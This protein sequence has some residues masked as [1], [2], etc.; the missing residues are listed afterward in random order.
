MYSV[1]IKWHR[2]LKMPSTTNV[3]LAGPDTDHMKCLS[4]TDWMS[5][6]WSDWLTEWWSYTIGWLTSFGVSPLAVVLPKWISMKNFYYV[7]GEHFSGAP[8]ATQCNTKI[9]FKNTHLGFYHS[10][11]SSLISVRFYWLKQVIHSFQ[12]LFFKNA[13]P[14]MSSNNEQRHAT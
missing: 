3:F 8:G 12:N 14:K 5:D 10:K 1:N 11:S 13:L 7:L 9:S 4:L 6:S 2:S